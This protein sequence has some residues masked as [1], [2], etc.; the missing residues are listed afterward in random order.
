MT[1]I[2]EYKQVQNPS[3]LNITIYE[4]HD[5]GKPSS[6]KFVMSKFTHLDS[7]AFIH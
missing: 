2:V 3:I 6:N 4:E 5:I 1:M 7:W